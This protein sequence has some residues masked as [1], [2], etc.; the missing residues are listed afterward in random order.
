MSQAADV[1]RPGRAGRSRR[2]SVR[3]APKP[4]A[5]FMSHTSMSSPI[6]CSPQKTPF[7]LFSQILLPI[8]LT[9]L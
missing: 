6:P 2:I 3:Q 5:D 1:G 7:R 8:F 9:G 4:T